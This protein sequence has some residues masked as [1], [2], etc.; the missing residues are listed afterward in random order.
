MEGLGYFEGLEQLERT[1]IFHHSE[2]LAIAFG[3]I[4]NT[5]PTETIRVIKN[6]RVCRECHAAGKVIS[7]MVD[8]EIVV[9]DSSRFHHLRDGSCSCKDYW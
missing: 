9:R 4:I 2:N 6:L 1:T 3:L 7:K 5:L 8:R